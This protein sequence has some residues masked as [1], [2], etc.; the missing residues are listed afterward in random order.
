MK[1]G[2]TRLM[3]KENSLPVIDI[4]PSRGWIPVNFSELWAFRELLYFLIWREV[5]VRYKQ[6]VLGFTW[7]IIR[8]L[9]NG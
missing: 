6:T 8:P 5:K 4:R 7:A 2:N 1:V 9:S 3:E